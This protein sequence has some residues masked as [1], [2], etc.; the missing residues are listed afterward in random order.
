MLPNIVVKRAVLMLLDVSEVWNRT[1][2]IVGV[3][4]PLAGW[5]AH[6]LTTARH[7]L[8][9][10]DGDPLATHFGL[11]LGYHAGNYGASL[12]GVNRG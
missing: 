8:R 6:R 2:P 10:A 3:H 4:R 12:S 1:V 11:S 7:P 5:A 9:K